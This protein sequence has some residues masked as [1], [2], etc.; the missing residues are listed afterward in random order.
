MKTFDINWRYNLDKYAAD[1]Y[2][3]NIKSS[4]FIHHTPEQMKFNEVDTTILLKSGKSMLALDHDKMH[5]YSL[6]DSKWREIC[7]IFLV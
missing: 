1:H 5:K 6:N 7:T 3:F 4:G 2:I